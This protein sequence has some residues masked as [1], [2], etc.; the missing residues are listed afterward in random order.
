MRRLQMWIAGRDAAAI[1]VHGFNCVRPC[2]DGLMS[3]M[4]Q[5]LIASRPL[6]SAHALSTE[7]RARLL[8]TSRQERAVQSQTNN[9]V[10]LRRI[11]TLTYRL[12]TA[13]EDE[14]TSCFYGPGVGRLRL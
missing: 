3:A 14:D 8:T 6:Q 5:A 13:D 2:A 11:P 7:R 4:V 9:L 12:G 10:P 1:R